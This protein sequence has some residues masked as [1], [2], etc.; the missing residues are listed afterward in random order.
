MVERNSHGGTRPRE[1]IAISLATLNIS[2]ET[3]IESAHRG[4]GKHRQ[5]DIKR[6]SIRKRLTW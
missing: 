3:T 1:A 5:F 6:Y 4:Q 2:V